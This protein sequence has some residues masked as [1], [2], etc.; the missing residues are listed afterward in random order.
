MT[1]FGPNDR[2]QSCLYVVLLRAELLPSRGSGKKAT[3]GVYGPRPAKYRLLGE[4]W[5]LLLLATLL[6][7]CH[8][9]NLQDEV[10][11][12]RVEGVSRLVARRLVTVRTAA[13]TVVTTPEHPFAKVGA[14]WTRAADL[15]RGDR[16]QTAGGGDT[17]ILGV[18]VREV[19][20][21][22]VHNLTVSK[23][24]AYFVGSRALLV[25]NTDCGPS[26]SGSRSP[27]PR[28]AAAESNELREQ[29]RARRAQRRASLEARRHEQ[30]LPLREQF[31]ARRARRKALLETERREREREREQHQMLLDPFNDMP[32]RPNCGYCTLAALS[33]MDNV[34]TLFREMDLDDR[35]PNRRL[36]LK[37]IDDV[38]FEWG[39]TSNHTPPPA[40]FPASRAERLD[41][42]NK[43]EQAA[44]NGHAP[45]IFPFQN[46]AKKFMEMSS[47]NTFVVAFSAYHA[48]N[49][50]SHV[51]V[52]VKRDD[53]SIVYVDPQ[54]VPPLIHYD[55]DPQ[56][57]VVLATPTDVDWRNNRHLSN[58][59]R[60]G[61]HEPLATW[62]SSTD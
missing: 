47:S 30:S 4:H 35:N 10:A 15:R 39:L 45:P 23:T 28:P 57:H 22:V 33:D 49:Y 56:C 2:H 50:D 34:S 52:A 13:A 1:R 19:Q 44:R 41:A 5:V 27:A 12:A 7:G 60:N 21:T 42:R 53:G 24:H 9:T 32:N 54:A 43:V 59:V 29:F 51:L 11:A 20:P 58:F 36:T 55:L 6:C 8:P 37:E 3:T 16:V 62:D 18:E 61:V 26:S 38:L 40:T 48:P 31:R 17:T 25:H 46:A 14:G